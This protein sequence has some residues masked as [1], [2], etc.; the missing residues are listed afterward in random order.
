MLSKLKKD[1]PF[2][3]SRHI[4]EWKWNGMRI[5]GHCDGGT[6]LL[7]GRSGADYTAQFPEI[8][9][10]ASCLRVFDSAVLDGEMVCLGEDGLPDFNRMQRRYN[11]SDPLIIRRM[12]EKFPANF[13]VFDVPHLDGK[14]LTAGG[15]Q[16]H[17]MQR[18]EILS[19]ILVPDD[20]IKL[21]PWVDTQGVALYEK[22]KSL[23]QEGIVA[24]TKEGLYYPGGRVEDWQ[25]IKVP[26]TGYF[27]I[28]GYTQGTGWRE[29]LLGAVILGLPTENGGGLRLVGKA[30]T[31]LKYAQLVDLFG[32]LQRIRT[33]D[34]PFLPGT[35]VPKVASWVSPMLVAEVNYGDVTKDGMLIWPSFQQVRTHL[36]AED[37]RYQETKEE[38]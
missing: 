33:E 27:L 26:R 35:K 30:G 2:D 12:A 34:S 14:D 8:Q 19:Q 29:E 24:K 25:K 37:C 23:G 28:G 15:L 21:S 38:S 18:K 7:R 9:H 13:M 36:A 6:A 3:S 4:F 22:V 5:E 10:L 17:Q 20:R 32:A 1:G 31:G 16:A 11:Q